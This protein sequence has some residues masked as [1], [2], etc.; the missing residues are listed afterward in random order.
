MAIIPK[1]D[2]ESCR[3]YFKQMKEI[4]S[5]LKLRNYKNIEMKYLSMGMTEDYKAAISEGSNMIRVGTGIFGKR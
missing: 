1:G 2:V 5:S 3:Q 4:W